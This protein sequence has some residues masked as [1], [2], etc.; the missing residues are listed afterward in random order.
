MAPMDNPSPRPEAT[1]MEPNP[2]SPPMLL[3]SRQK[4]PTRGSCCSTRIGRTKKKVFRAW[5]L[6]PVP[7]EMV[8]TDGPEGKDQNVLSSMIPAT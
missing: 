7:G 4:F 5:Q 6:F 1:T 3:T 8:R 2:M